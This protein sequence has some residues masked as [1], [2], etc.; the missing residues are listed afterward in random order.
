[1][2]NEIEKQK[3]K[4]Q[5]K[6][7]KLEREAKRRMEAELRNSLPPKEVVK[8]ISSDGILR[9]SKSSDNNDDDIYDSGPIEKKRTRNEFIFKIINLK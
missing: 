8:T 6:L 5:M 9:V 1:M 4:D 3:I 2:K 7:D